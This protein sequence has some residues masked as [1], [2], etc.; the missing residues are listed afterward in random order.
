[1][2]TARRALVTTMFLGIAGLASVAVAASM[3][4][5]PGTGCVETNDSTPEI[6]YNNGHAF[7]NDASADAVFDCPI[8]RDDSDVQGPMTNLFAAVDDSH[9][10]EAVRCHVRSCNWS[11]STC[12]VSS[13]A[14][15]QGVGVTNLSLGSVVAYTN[16]HAHLVCDVP[17]RYNGDRSGV[18][19]YRVYD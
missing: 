2:T 1:M 12:S 14:S 13:T 11:G 19:S 4:T 10:S 9:P 7:N 3:T 5:F 8:K 16:G 15:S 18:I 6:L 17:N